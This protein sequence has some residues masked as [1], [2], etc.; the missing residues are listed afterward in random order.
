LIHTD[1]DLIADVDTECRAGVCSQVLVSLLVTVVLGDVVQVFPADDDGAGH[2]GR[3]DAAS[4]DAATDG[5]ETGPWALLVD[6]LAVDGSPRSLEA[7]TDI[8]V[9]SLDARRL[10]RGLRVEE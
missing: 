5:D 4:Q 7:K 9:P 10:A 6:V 1:C 8:L 2:L 3:D